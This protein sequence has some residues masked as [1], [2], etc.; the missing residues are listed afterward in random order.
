ME[1]HKASKENGLARYTPNTIGG[2]LGGQVTAF[3]EALDELKPFD[4][5]KE[6]GR[7]VQMHFTSRYVEVSVRLH[8]P[9]LVPREIKTLLKTGSVSKK[10]ASET[11]LHQTYQ[12]HVCSC[13]L[14]AAREMFAVCRLKEY[15]STA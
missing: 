8:G 13:A 15:S 10:P 14:R 2:V 3:K 12:K 6:I 11:Y 4:E 1:H 7:N 9:E 5:I